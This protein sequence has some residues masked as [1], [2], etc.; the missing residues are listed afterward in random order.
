MKSR[1]SP[2][3]SARKRPQQERSS[4]LVADILEAAIRVLVREGARRFTTARVAE[5]AGVSVGSLYQYFPNKEA[6]L[7]RLQA[8]E[9]RQ[10][11]DL[12]ATL[13]ADTKRAPLDRLRATV[14]EFFRTEYEEAAL[15]VALG[16]AAPL[17]RD[18]PEAVTLK[19]AT[20][21]Q[22]HA[23]MAEALPDATDE[24]HAFA[25]EF[26]MTSMAV[27]GEH[28][29]GDAHSKAEVDRW[30]VAMGDMLCAWLD[31]L[32]RQPRLKS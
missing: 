18:A 21:K 2:E 6:I 5:E 9:W 32:S 7:F 16:D 4:R 17:Y 26:V 30:A 15:R 24:T 20:M 8:D 13:L 25:A 1:S 27:L 14:R 3:I 29:S 11:S 12:I 22:A 31:Q 10:T 28:V 19:A 23:F